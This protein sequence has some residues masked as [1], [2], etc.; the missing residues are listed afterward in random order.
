MAKKGGKTKLFGWRYP[1]FQ[2]RFSYFFRAIQRRFSPERIENTFLDYPAS[3]FRP[4]Q[5][6]YTP[7]S[8]PINK[9]TTVFHGLHSYRPRKRC[10]KMFKTEVKPRAAGEWFHCKCHILYT[11]GQIHP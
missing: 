11:A 2:A 9:S 10:H 8:G 6:Q 5:M 1:G 7:V 4:L 3:T